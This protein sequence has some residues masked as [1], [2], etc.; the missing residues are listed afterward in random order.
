MNQVHTQDWGAVNVGS[1]SRP[2]AKAKTGV[3]KR[4]GTLRCVVFE[5]WMEKKLFVICIAFNSMVIALTKPLKF[6]LFSYEQGQEAMHRHTAEELCL[7][8]RYVALSCVRVRDELF[9][10]MVAIDGN[11][12]V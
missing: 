1:S 6:F 10:E 4:Y 8:G 7:Q 12:D 3:A 9:M 2:N 11:V 5:L